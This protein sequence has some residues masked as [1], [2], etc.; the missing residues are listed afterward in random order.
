MLFRS[1]KLLD[2]EGLSNNTNRG[3]NYM[4]P[5]WARTIELASWV[6]EGTCTGCTIEYNHTPAN[7]P[8]LCAGGANAGLVCTVANEETDCP[9][10]TC[11]AQSTTSR[12]ATCAAVLGATGSSAS[13]I[14]TSDAVVALPGLP[15]DTDD[16]TNV[17]MAMP[18]N[19]SI[20]N[21]TYSGGSLGRVQVWVR[22]Q[23]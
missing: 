22:F 4:V 12:F 2:H 5:A 6:V 18:G 16:V 20:R 23:P 11:D 3:V 13:C 21:S 8:S 9:L 7:L 17:S 1:V 14:V 10:S 15:W 19:F